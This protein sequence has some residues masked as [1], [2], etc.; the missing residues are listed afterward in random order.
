MFAQRRR[1]TQLS[2]QVY[3]VYSYMYVQ[4][5]HYAVWL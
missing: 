2:T 4:C 1:F 5:T 3:V